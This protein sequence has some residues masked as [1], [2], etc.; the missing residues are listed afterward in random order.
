MRMIPEEKIN[1][2]L[3]VALILILLIWGF[4]AMGICNNM[5]E[6]NIDIS[7][8]KASQPFYQFSDLYGNNA[9][10][11]SDFSEKQSLCFWNGHYDIECMNDV[12]SYMGEKYGKRYPPYIDRPNRESQ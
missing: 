3:P 4:V 11:Y 12:G 9:T 6:L 5:I 8:Q 1:Y 10:I 7:H 2:G